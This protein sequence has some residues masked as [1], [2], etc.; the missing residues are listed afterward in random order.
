M[1]YILIITTFAVLLFVSF[2]SFADDQT[3]TSAKVHFELLTVNGVEFIQ[4]Q[5]IQSVTFPSPKTDKKWVIIWVH[6]GT[7]HTSVITGGAVT[8]TYYPK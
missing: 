7:T 5:Y 1:R 4:A 6:G 8:L 3:L 2:A